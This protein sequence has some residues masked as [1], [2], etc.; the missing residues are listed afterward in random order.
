MKTKQPSVFWSL[1]LTALL[2]IEVS[3]N[4]IRFDS[5]EAK[6]W[7]VVNDTVMG[8]ISN[9]RFY[10]E[11]SYGVFE[12]EVSL[13]NNGGF[14]SVRRVISPEF[15]NG[16]IIRLIVKGDGRRYQFRLKTH[17]L[18]EGAAYVAE[19]TTK[20][21]KWQQIQFTEKDFTPRYR[22]RYVNGAPALKFGDAQQ[23][24]L[25]IADK[26]AGKFKLQVKAIEVLQA[27]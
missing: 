27:I 5:V 16:S 13:D 3:A 19:F 10:H 14:A 17:Q 8:G 9:S 11:V 2:T 23:V 20:Q 1:T 22:G 12:G 15:N 25:L 7:T 26:I 18:Y 6:H 21:N 4:D 24:G